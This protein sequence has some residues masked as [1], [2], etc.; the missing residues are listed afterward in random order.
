MVT[1]VTAPTAMLVTSK[2][3]V[4][5]PSFTVTVAGTVA[6]SLSD[7]SDTT[8]PPAGAA[9]LRVIVPVEELPPATFAGINDRDEIPGAL[10]VRSAVLVTPFAE[11]EIVALV[12]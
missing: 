11:A 9:P 8:V 12:F 10:I 1:F 5:A 4:V 7:E 3:A 2:V 6:A